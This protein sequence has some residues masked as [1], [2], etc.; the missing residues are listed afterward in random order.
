MDNKD[1]QRLGRLKVSCE[2]IYGKNV[3]PY[4]AWP[5]VSFAG[6]Q[7]GLFAIPEIGDGIYVE[8]EGGNPKYPIWGG[9]WWS[10]P[11]AVS[12]VPMTARKSPPTNRV[13]Q[14]RSGHMIELDDTPGEEK[15]KI[16]DKSGNHIL[17]DSTTKNEEHLVQNNK[18]DNV[19]VDKQETIGANKISD[20]T[21]NKEETIGGNKT[22]DITGDKTETVGGDWM[23]TVVGNATIK[24]TNIFLDDKVSTPD[25]VITGKSICHFTGLVHA[26][27]SLTVKASKL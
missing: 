20:I 6:N 10:K 5:K 23:I 24:A 1:P 13:L 21:N 27:K 25:G 3:P 19:T 17:I 11:G 8:C 16:T 18:I 14:T 15:I 22:S 7:I 26:D 2:S 4:W 12:E 9:G